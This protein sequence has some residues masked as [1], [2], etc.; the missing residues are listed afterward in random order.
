MTFNE[1]Y[2]FLL[3][4]YTPSEIDI[5]RAYE[6]FQNE[7]MQSTGKT[8][9]KNK[10]LQRASN[11]IFYGDMN[12]FIAVRPQHSGYVKLVGAA[13]SDKSKYKG[14]KEL[15]STHKPVWGMVDLKI[16][17]IL[18]KLGYR[19]PNL[20]ERAAM[21][22]FFTPEKMASVLGGANIDNIQGDKVTIT[23]PD[24]GTV[25]KYFIA[26]PEYWTK[27]KSFY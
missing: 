4:A 6:L 1:T 26:S 19:G 22:L 24:I 3:E 13:G 7:Y 10:F 11:W 12:G 9:D 8:W 2:R 16:K 25:E 14:F 27:V 15:A 17:N 18:S 20:I 21:K 5:D 23:Y